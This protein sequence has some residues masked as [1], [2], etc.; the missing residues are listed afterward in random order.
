MVSRPRSRGEDIGDGK[1]G[2]SGSIVTSPA[3]PGFFEMRATIRHDDKTE[4]ITGEFLEELLRKAIAR[5]RK[6]GC[7]KITLRLSEGV[8]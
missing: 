2:R 4:S 8:L 5:A 3:S 6:R 1:R 7:K